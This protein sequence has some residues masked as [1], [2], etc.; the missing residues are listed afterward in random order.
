MRLRSITSPNMP[1]LSIEAL[2]TEIER[3]G[4]RLSATHLADGKVR[5]NRWRTP[6]GVI[7]A[8]QI[9]DLW[10]SQIGVNTERI[11]ELTK[12]LLRRTQ[13][14]APRNKKTNSRSPRRSRNCRK[15]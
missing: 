14:P 3:L 11:D 9:E 7:N 13:P 12:Y 6:D 4:L 1:Q 15:R 10:A 8:Q 2:V 5:L